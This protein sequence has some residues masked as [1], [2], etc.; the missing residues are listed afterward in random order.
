[1]DV[2]YAPLRT[3]R[4]L[5]WD[6][7]DKDFHFWRHVLW[8]DETK[9]DHNGHRYIWRKKW[10]AWRMRTSSQLWS[11][12]V[13][14]WCCGGVLCFTVG[15]TG[16]LHKINGIMR[17]EHYVQIL[18]KHLKTLSRK[19]RLLVSVGLQ[20][21]DDPKHTTRLATEWLQD[22]KVSVLEWTSQ[23]PDLSPVRQGKANLFV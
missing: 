13:A 9:T 17:K 8:P 21:D 6:H 16:E 15:G 3:R 10:E 22:N 7:R 11:S 18:K 23:R 1:M 2:F 4:L 5:V 20:R 14:A 12:G 19:L